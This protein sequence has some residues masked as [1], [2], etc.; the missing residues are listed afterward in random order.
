MVLRRPQEEEMG[1]H[2]EQWH[3]EA[4]RGSRSGRQQ[5]EALTF[6]VWKNLDYQW[7]PPL[8]PVL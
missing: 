6:E 1:R 7:L 8:V 5:G 3:S 2:C 4:V